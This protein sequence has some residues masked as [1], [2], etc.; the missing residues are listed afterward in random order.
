MKY[1]L[2]FGYIGYETATPSG[3]M[4]GK[5]ENEPVDSLEKVIK[6]FKLNNQK[7]K[8]KVD[9]DLIYQDEG[10]KKKEVKSIWKELKKGEHVWKDLKNKLLKLLELGDKLLPLVFDINYKNLE[11]QVV[12]G[13]NTIHVIGK[14]LEKLKELK[15]LINIEAK[16]RVSP[17]GRIGQEKVKLQR[18]E[19]EI[20]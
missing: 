5:A 7:A 11:I 14:D 1:I 13:E 20:K 15:K 9:S 3:S 6:F 19:V 12:D 10:S 8:I 18:K 16:K 17:Y 4:S 2:T